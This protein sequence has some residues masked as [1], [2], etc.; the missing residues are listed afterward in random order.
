[1]SDEKSVVD[2]GENDVFCLD[3][4]WLKY[5]E[6]DGTTELARKKS[7]SCVVTRET[8]VPKSWL[9]D[10][11]KISVDDPPTIPEVKNGNNDCVD[12]MP[13]TSRHYGGEL[14]IAE[15]F[16]RDGIPSGEEVSLRVLQTRSAGLGISFCGLRRAMALLGMTDGETSPDGTRY[17]RMP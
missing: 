4:K 7:Y 12:Y 10:G 6:L 8:W 5:V 1:M 2:G 17:W 3:C 9:R 15:K 11:H 14:A 13:S 16:L